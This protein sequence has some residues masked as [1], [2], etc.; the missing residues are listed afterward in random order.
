MRK[1]KL[2]TKNLILKFSYHKNSIKRV[3]FRNKS[4]SEAVEVMSV[5]IYGWAKI[6]LRGICKYKNINKNKN[7]YKMKA[8]EEYD[9]EE[10]AE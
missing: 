5:F 7:F 10:E 2:I 6:I 8:I 4:Y 9:G 1:L 3:K